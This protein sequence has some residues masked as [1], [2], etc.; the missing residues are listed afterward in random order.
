[1]ETIT[2]KEIGRRLASLRK[3]KGYLQDDLAKILDIPR[4]SLTQI[5]LG[6]RNLSVL[7]LKKITDILSI[8]IDNFLS[9]DFNLSELLKD[10]NMEVEENQEIRVS[11]P[12]MNLKK[13]KNILYIS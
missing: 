9:T 3:S 6:K 7:E 5:E 10:E 1:M 12:E 13:F 11:I 2:Q 8:T 4:P